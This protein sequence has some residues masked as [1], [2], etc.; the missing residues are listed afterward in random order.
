MV[1]G[2]PGWALEMREAE[3]CESVAEREA[4]RAG[5]LLPP[6]GRAGGSSAAG[7]GVPGASGSMP[8]ILLMLLVLLPLPLPLL[9]GGAVLTEEEEATLV[10]MESMAEEVAGAGAPVELVLESCVRMEATPDTA[11]V[12]R[13]SAALLVL[14]LLLP[15]APLLLLLLLPLLLLLLLEGGG[16]CED[17]VSSAAVAAV[18]EL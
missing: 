17:S 14:E 11:A 9:A 2:A 7:M 12:E 6:V 3:S 1:G 4:A 15:L 13:A 10:R 16:S 18:A 5:L 8:G